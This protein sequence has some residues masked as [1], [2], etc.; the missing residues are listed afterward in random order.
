MKKEQIIEFIDKDLAFFPKE[1][2]IC[3]AIFN[4]ICS[5][6]KQ[7]LRHITFN[8]LKKQAGL[9]DAKD[10]ITATT[11]LTGDRVNLLELKFEFIENDI[12][13]D[14]A[15]EDVMQARKDKVFYHPHKGEIVS[16]FESKLFMYFSLGKNGETVTNG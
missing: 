13:E 15:I 14:V 12:V 10:V 7:N 3:R 11:Y 2:S 16:D 9:L 1:K 8:T 6:N 5:E 4:Y